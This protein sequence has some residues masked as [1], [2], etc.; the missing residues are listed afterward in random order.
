MRAH[1][2]LECALVERDNHNHA[3]FPLSQAHDNFTVRVP[4]R[5]ILFSLLVHSGHGDGDS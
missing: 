3:V 5:V 2:L 4:E 1:V